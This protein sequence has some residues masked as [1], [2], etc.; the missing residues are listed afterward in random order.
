MFG[1]MLNKGK[2]ILI[3]LSGLYASSRETALVQQEKPHQSRL[4]PMGKA[5]STVRDSP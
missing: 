2:F 4:D 5:T 1:I 3:W